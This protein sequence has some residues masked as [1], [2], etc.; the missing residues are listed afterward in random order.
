M[1]QVAIEQKWSF[2]AGPDGIGLSHPSVGVLLKGTGRVQLNRAEALPPDIGFQDGVYVLRFEQGI[3]LTVGIECARNQ[4][5]LFPVLSNEG[6]QAVAIGDVALLDLQVEF[7]TC[8][9]HAFINGKNM[10]ENT[11]LVVLQ[12]E[13]VS[14]S[15]LGLTDVDGTQ[16]FAIGAIRPDDAW[17]DFSVSVNDGIAQ[18]LKIICRLEDTI[19][20]SQTSRVLSPIRLYSD[21]SLALLMERYAEDVAEQMVPLIHFK[22]PP[23]GWCSWYHY[24]GTDDVDD[25]RKNMEAI[26]ASPL[27]N[28]LEVIQI[29]DGW[30]RAD[31]NTPR[32]WGDWVPGGKYPDGM[33]VLADEIHANGFQAG[34]WLAPFSVDAASQ[35]YRD[36]PDWLVQAMG[37][38]GELD[39][40]AAPGGVFGLDLTNPEVQQFVRE[41]FR[42]VFKEWGFDYI[43]IDFIAHGAIEGHRLDQTKTGIEAFRIGMRII[44]EEAGSDKFIL[45]CGSPILASVGLC[46]GMRIGMDV[47]GRWFAPMNLKEWRHGNCCLK[48][49]A[50]STL[51]RQWMHR[52]WWHNDPDCIILRNRMTQE[53]WEAFHNHPLEDEP[54]EEGDFS[55]SLEETLGWLRLV[56]LSGGMCI[57]SEDMAGL[58][59]EQWAALEKMWPLNAQPVRWVDD[60]RHPDVGVLQTTSGARIIG[61]FN[62]SDEPVSLTLAAEKIGVS[63]PCKFVER[64]T[65]NVFFGEGETIVFPELSAHGGCLWMLE[66]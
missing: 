16:A 56:W 58:S 65:G 21:P 62:L 28:R 9:S 50:N 13:A 41:T 22:T 60:Y 12:Q 7:A 23:S 63:S 17:Y 30:N 34:L 10:V 51:W 5:T 46:D 38:A 18:G 25:I 37:D 33:E 57:A 64:L 32:N 11:G 27:K 52:V 44:R 66:E 14:N 19:L 4:M 20:A 31:R 59:G 6:D 29:D 35:L 42:R 61:I 39:P 53:E 1:E 48:A 40:L 24:Y 2:S 8:F 47:G 45:N 15:I 3:V 36:H 26:Q 49:A 55:L 43:K 54:V